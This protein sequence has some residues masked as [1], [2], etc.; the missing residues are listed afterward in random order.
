MAIGSPV[1]AGTRAGDTQIG[2]FQEV[3]G[4]VTLLGVGG[5]E[6][7]ASDIVGKQCTTAQQPIDVVLSNSVCKLDMNFDSLGKWENVISFKGLLKDG[8]YLIYY[9]YSAKVDLT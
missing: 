7:R 2:A 9:L 3:P 8:N 4:L 5:I 1:Q 6:P